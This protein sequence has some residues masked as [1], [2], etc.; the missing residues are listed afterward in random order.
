M[1]FRDIIACFLH[2]MMYTCRILLC[3]L[4]RGVDY[5]PTLVTTFE[6]I[7]KDTKKINIDPTKKGLLSERVNASRLQHTD[8]INVILHNART[9]VAQIQ[10][11]HITTG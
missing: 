7:L 1:D 10:L 5:S 8:Y 3:E 6:K 4:L 9:V 11:I 2:L